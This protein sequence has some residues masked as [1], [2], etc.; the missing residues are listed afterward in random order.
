MQ[1]ELRHGQNTQQ[2]GES[3]QVIFPTDKTNGLRSVDTK[4]YDYGKSTC[5]MFIKGN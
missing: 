1:K 2:L 5:E 4:I 3:D